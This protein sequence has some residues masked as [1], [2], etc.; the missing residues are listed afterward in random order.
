MYLAL[1]REL[2]LY[3]FQKGGFAYAVITDYAYFLTSS[4]LEADCI[5]KS[6]SCCALS[7]GNIDVLDLQYVQRRFHSIGEVYLCMFGIMYRLFD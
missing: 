6:F 7:D 5:N 3:Y 1:V 2:F 4:D